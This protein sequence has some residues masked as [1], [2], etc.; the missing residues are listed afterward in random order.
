MAILYTP[1]DISKVLIELRIDPVDGKVDANEAARILSWRAKAEQ[2]LDYEYAPDA[3]RQ[4]VRAN[5]FEE[6][7]ID[8]KK[9]GSRY[10]V[11][12]VFRLPIVPKRRMGRKPVEEEVAPVEDQKGEVA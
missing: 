5:R 11:D 8:L 4:H 9:R 1:E 3:I 12:Q 7:S 10:P 2:D 6:G